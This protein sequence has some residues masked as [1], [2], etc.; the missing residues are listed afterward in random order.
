MVG[1]G[2]GDALYP[3]TSRFSGSGWVGWRRHGQ[4]ILVRFAGSQGC[5]HSPLDRFSGL[6]YTPHR[7][8]NKERNMPSASV[9]AL[10]SLLNTKHFAHTLIKPWVV[11]APARVLA[12]GV[13][14]LDAMLAGGWR[15][16][17][18]SELIG[19]SSSGRTSV[20]AASLAAAA[21]QGGLVALVDAMDQLDPRRLARTG[22]ELERLLWVRGP[23]LTPT[24]TRVL[25]ERA[26]R[27]AIRAFDL[28]VR[29]G[30]FSLVVLDVADMPPPVL[31]ALPATTWMRIARSNEGRPA[32]CLLVGSTPLGRSARGVTVQLSGSRCWSGASLQSHRLM[33]I[34]ADVRA[35]ASHAIFG[36]TRL[37]LGQPAS[38]GAHDLLSHQ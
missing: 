35:G 12:T 19:P 27:Q 1:K 37:E 10:E 29:A 20:Y 18:V 3:G 16:G 38:E 6:V 7:R 15:Q 32:V 36:T 33:G 25:L 24:A 9:A 5:R 31:R 11:E 21:S 8:A 2:A 22:C 30:G 17:E 28:I 13:A 34:A 4:A 23:S 26:L 14:G